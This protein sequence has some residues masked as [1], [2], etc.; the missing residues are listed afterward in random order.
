[1]KH[2]VGNTPDQHVAVVQCCF[3]AD[4]IERRYEES[5]HRYLTIAVL[6][7]LSTAVLARKHT[8]RAPSRAVNLPVFLASLICN[9]E[10]LQHVSYTKHTADF[11]QKV[12][13]FIN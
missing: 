12:A 4:S 1:M 8:F 6:T 9:Y 10:T 11:K 7:E 5:L 2:A 13:A 3:Q